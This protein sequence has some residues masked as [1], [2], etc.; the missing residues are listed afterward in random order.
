MIGLSKDGVFVALGSWLLRTFKLRWLLLYMKM[1]PLFTAKHVLKSWISL[2]S[3][4][5]QD[6]Q[7]STG[8]STPKGTDVLW[9]HVGLFFVHFKQIKTSLKFL[10]RV[11]YCWLMFP[12][13]GTC[14]TGEEW[15]VRM[16]SKYVEG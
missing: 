16:W 9:E 6:T 10:A 3:S 4:L 13:L 12:H 5:R 7:V 1:L 15:L 11:T 2:G 14:N 8:T